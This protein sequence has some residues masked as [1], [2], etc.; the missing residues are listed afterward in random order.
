[1]DGPQAEL[2]Q[3]LTLMCAAS[4]TQT[5]DQEVIIPYVGDEKECSHGIHF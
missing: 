2:G 5:V 4:S 3:G 1:M